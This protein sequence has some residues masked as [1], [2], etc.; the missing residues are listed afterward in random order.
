VGILNIYG[1]GL[2]ILKLTIAFNII[3]I[4]VVSYK[5]SMQK[6][7]LLVFLCWTFTNSFGQKNPTKIYGTVPIN[8]FSSMDATEVTINEWISFIINNNFNTAL[9]PDSLSISNST[10]VLFNDLKKGKDF[11]YIEIIDNSKFL[12]ENYGSRGFR[13]TKKF[14]N[15]VDADTNYFSIYNPIVGISFAQAQKFCKWREAVVNKTKA[16]KIKITLPSIEIYKKV[17]LNKDSLCKAELNCDSCSGYQLNYSHKKCTL[18]AKHKEIITQ[19]EG[20][21]RVDS[22][23]PSILGLYNIQG[24]AAEM[25][26]IEGIAVGGSFRHFAADS[27]SDK[28]QSYSKEEDWLVFRCLVTLQ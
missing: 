18:S 6:V 10:R 15:L 8:N 17:N 14:K 23:W 19:G 20:L 28:T 22:Y 26:S 25:T 7:L 1:N 27:Y 12:R 2:S 16:V 3:Y 11:E 4:C 21:L 9:F 5:P 13:V 24:N